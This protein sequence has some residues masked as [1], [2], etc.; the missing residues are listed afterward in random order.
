M[1][2]EV[3]GDLITLAKSGSFDVIAHGCNCHSTMGAGIAPQMAKA[4]GCDLFELE[5]Y[6]GDINKLGQIDY[7]TVVLGKD[8]IFSLNEFKN[9]RNEPELTVVNLYSQYNYGA[10]HKDGV[11]RPIDYEAL[12][13]GLRK[14]N[15]Q[16]KG[17]RIG[18]PG[19]IG[20]G[21]AGGDPNIVKSIIKKELKDCNVT[22]VYLK[23]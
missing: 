10:N 20:C 4:F 11:S 23:L 7:Q 3:Q 17:R 8:S 13:L 1:Y 12:T 14:M 15:H 19:L 5:K 22:I 2:N 9:N 21:L 6:P 18:L 16:F